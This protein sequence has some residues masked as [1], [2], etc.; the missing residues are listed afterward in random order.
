[1]S[2]VSKKGWRLSGKK[3]RKVIKKSWRLKWR[4]DEESE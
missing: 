4:E 2:I 3:M 1:M